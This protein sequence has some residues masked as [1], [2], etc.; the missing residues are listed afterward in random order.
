[1][2]EHLIRVT[3]TQLLAA[4]RDVVLQAATPDEAAQIVLDAV[5]GDPDDDTSTRSYGLPDGRKIELDPGDA[6]IG[7]EIYAE[8]IVGGQVVQTVGRAT[9]PIRRF[10]DLSTAHLQQADRLFLEFSA[11]PGSLGGLAAMAGIYGWFVYAHDERCCEGISDALWAVFKRARALGCDY[12]LFDADAPILED[13]P[14][15]EEEAEADEVSPP[16]P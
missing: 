15:F 13:L 10:L 5:A 3:Q 12:V 9:P 11:N 8:V 16:P 1:M 6:V 7:G 4:G 2:P 14:V